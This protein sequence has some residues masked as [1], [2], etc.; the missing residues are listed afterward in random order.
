MKWITLWI[1]TTTTMTL[2]SLSYFYLSQE[3]EM[4]GLLTCTLYL[5]GMGI[6]Y[7]LWKYNQIKFVEKRTIIIQV[8][9][10]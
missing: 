5:L 10:D 9:K 7:I 4:Y 1:L 3:L 2:L 8:L 6:P